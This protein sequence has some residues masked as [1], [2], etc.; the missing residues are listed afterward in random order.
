MTLLRTVAPSEAPVTLADAKAHLRV[1]HSDEDAY[2]SSLIDAAVA[3]VDGNGSLGRAMVTQTW[4]KWV[5]Q[6]PGVVRIGM[7]PFI[8]LT[9]V[10]Y[11]D[12]DSVLQAATVTDFEVRLDD[13]FVTVRPKDNK[14]WPAATTRE[15]AIRI[16]FTAGFGAASDVPSGLKHA[17]LLLVGLWYENREAA[18]DLTLKDIPMGVD[19]LIGMER[20]GWYG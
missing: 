3:M 10:S 19:A 18:S 5:S 20:V 4:A 9:D 2:I 13:D 11:Y 12:T 17:L 15:D 6:A 14:V 1:D 8:A 7:G 16:T